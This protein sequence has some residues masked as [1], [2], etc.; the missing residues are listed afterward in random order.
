MFRNDA[1]QIINLTTSHMWKL[2]TSTQLRA[3]WHTVSLDMVVLPCISDSLYNNY[4]IGSGTSPEYFRYT[5]ICDKVSPCKERSKHVVESNLY[6]V[7]KIVNWMEAIISQI[8][9]DFPSWTCIS[10]IYAWKTNKYTNYPFSLLI[11]YGSS[12]MFWH[13][14]CVAISDRHAPRH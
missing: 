11:M 2:P 7:Q 4:C 10:L 9:G 5:L 14:I 12:Y 6:E 1:V 13:G 3:T 8:S